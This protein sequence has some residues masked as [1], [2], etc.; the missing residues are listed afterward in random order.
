MSRKLFEK[1][2]QE[3]AHD[4]SKGDVALND[5][6][7]FSFPSEDNHQPMPTKTLNE[8]NIQEQVNNN[9]NGD[10]IEISDDEFEYSI[11]ICNQ[12]SPLNDND[13]SIEISDDEINY[14]MSHESPIAQPRRRKYPY[15]QNNESAAGL[16]ES[17]H[18]IFDDNF[19]LPA[20]LHL[21][22]NHEPTDELDLINQSVRSIVRKDF[23]SNTKPRPSGSSAGTPLR[24]TT[25]AMLGNT[26]NN[27]QP[28]KFLSRLDDTIAKDFSMDY[29]SFDDLLQG[30]NLP[31]S[32]RPFVKSPTPT[33]DEHE[34]TVTHDGS[35]F[36][37][38]IGHRCVSPKPNFEAMDSPTISRQLN[39]YGLKPLVRRKAIICLEHIYN[40]THPFVECPSDESRLKRSDFN[41]RPLAEVEDSTEANSFENSTNAYQ[42]E[43]LI[44]YTTKNSTSKSLPSDC[45][46]YFMN[47]QSEFY[48]PSPPRA[49]VTKNYIINKIN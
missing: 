49:K 26:S 39:K 8:L 36:E 21:R 43:S 14:S 22:L 16:N 45:F 6:L 10:S 29:D 32:S 44:L 2:L 7:S 12:I 40:R 23:V 3:N 4:Q 11:N 28:Q 5:S 31:D 18:Q 30:L 41:H 15:L 37:V 48:L 13:D 34:F 19:D 1:T 47:V 33:E 46:V 27:K 9:N 25:S 35:T 20:E 38:K 17:L 24:R 42:T